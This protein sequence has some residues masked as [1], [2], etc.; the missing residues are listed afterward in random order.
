[1]VKKSFRL[2]RTRFAEDIVAEA[3]LPER[4]Q[5]KVTIFCAGLPSSPNKKGLLEFLAARGYIAIF[6]RYRGTWESQ[7]NFLEYSP[8]QDIEDVIDD[9]VQ[10]GSILDLTTKERIPIKVSSVHLFG[11]SFGGPAVLMNSHLS[12]VKKIIA[13]SP[14]IDWKNEGETEPFGL[15]T[16]FVEDAFGDAY[17]LKH[18]SD[19]QKLVQ[20]DFYNP[21]NHTK[22]ITGQ[23]IF[24]IHA[25]ND[26]IVP[27][28]AV[29][30][31]SEK[32]GA[33]YYLKPHGGHGLD[34]RHG[35]LWKKIEAF[36]KKH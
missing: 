31:F 13:I 10:H 3:M 9:L 1:M 2:I 4:Q 35:F 21:I 33:S 14:V 12:I 30:P 8:A 25:K 15:H 26:T 29:I 28:D 18:A 19:W 27:C 36:L 32:T 23:K 11:S 24:I 6:P 5:G 16:Q 20:T 7:G 17:R 34:L 22:T